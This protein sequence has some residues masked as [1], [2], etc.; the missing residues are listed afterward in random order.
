MANSSITPTEDTFIDSKGIY[1]SAAPLEPTNFFE[2]DQRQQNVSQSGAPSVSFAEVV[3]PS[4]HTRPTT[5]FGPAKCTSVSPPAALTTQICGDRYVVPDPSTSS[6]NSR[7]SSAPARLEGAHSSR[8]H[9]NETDGNV[10]E[11]EED[12]C[13]YDS[14]ATIDIDDPSMPLADTGHPLRRMSES[15]ALVLMRQMRQGKFADQVEEL[16]PER[17]LR[18]HRWSICVPRSHISA[19]DVEDPEEEDE[20]DF[21]DDESDG[22][23][24]LEGEEED[25][26]GF[27]SGSQS[28][29]LSFGD[30]GDSVQNLRERLDELNSPLISVSKR[31]SVIQSAI[32]AMAGVEHEDIT[33]PFPSRA[34]FACFDDAKSLSEPSVEG[35]SCATQ[36]AP[37]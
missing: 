17:S 35:D 14:D 30:E 18:G 2:L 36:E 16:T 27:D 6:S 8:Y 10:E 7:R 19:L 5:S 13:D 37:F 1:S 26:D 4:P 29:F 34:S 15:Y 31:L 9:S 28:S 24:E 22:S 33:T 23:G 21:G 32:E 20:E 3:P 11:E 12:D 25:W